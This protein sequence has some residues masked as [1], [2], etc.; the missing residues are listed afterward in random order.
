VLAVDVTSM[1]KVGSSIGIS[2]A[3][4]EISTSLCFGPS[5]HFCI[6]NRRRE[7]TDVAIT[8]VQLRVLVSWDVIGNHQRMVINI[9]WDAYKRFIDG[10]FE[11][12]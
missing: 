3:L 12:V 1:C 10:M 9:L 6:D 11:E 2:S 5:K 8:R 4:Q 7:L